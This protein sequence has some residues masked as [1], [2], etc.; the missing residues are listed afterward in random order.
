[1]KQEI[2]QLFTEKEEAFSSLLIGIGMQKRSARVLVYLANIREATSREI[3]RGADMRQP[4]VS[5]GVRFL[6]KQGWV[7]HRQIPS[8]GHGRPLNIFSLAVPIKEIIT[9]ID[10][11][12]TEETSR[13]LEMVKRMRTFVG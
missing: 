12:K 5:V 7:K 1:M 10:Q 13:R 2:I 9:A 6:E 11:Q 8:R 4:E 3:E